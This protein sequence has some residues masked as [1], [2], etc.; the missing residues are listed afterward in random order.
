LILSSF[1]QY[2]RLSTHHPRARSFLASTNINKQAVAAR[3]SLYLT[4]LDDEVTST[5]DEAEADNFLLEASDLL[6]DDSS[7]GGEESLPASYISAQRIA[8][9]RLTHQRHPTDTGSP[10]Y[11]IAGMTERIAHLTSH[12]KSHPKDFSTRRGLV[13][14]VN[15]RRR[16]LNYLYSED[17]TK[18]AEI[19]RALGI[20]HKVPGSVP[21]KEDEYGEFPSQKGGKKGKSKM[22]K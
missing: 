12:L 4:T 2:S 17:E 11:Q 22:K 1:F 16:L 3:S 5:I 19:V 15:K 6:D 18:Y 9:L 20:R 13:A 10:E 14:L 8:S 7:S 21:S